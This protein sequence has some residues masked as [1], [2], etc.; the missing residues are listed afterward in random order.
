MAIVLDCR[1]ADG[2]AQ[3]PLR[4][5]HRHRCGVGGS[6][7]EFERRASST[8]RTVED[9]VG[10]LIGLAI[11]LVPDHTRLIRQ[12]SARRE[13]KTE[14]ELTPKSQSEINCLCGIRRR[15]TEMNDL[16]ATWRA[17][18]VLNFFGGTKDEGREREKDRESLG[19][20]V[21]VCIRRLFY[22]SG[23][24][25]LRFPS[26]T[27]TRHGHHTTSHFPDIARLVL[28]SRTCREQ[29]IATSEF[30]FSRWM[31]YRSIT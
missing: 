13:K 27:S 16:S 30:G 22:S 6:P 2:I 4:R 28:W 10:A 17:C 31:L 15:E 9:R 12:R 19:E 29:T 1:A 8:I 21:S 26:I 23:N 11:L 5:R 18:A 25:A 14:S 3:R 24:D 20:R 7:S